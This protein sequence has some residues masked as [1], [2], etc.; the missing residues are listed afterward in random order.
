MKCNNSQRKRLVW[1]PVTSKQTLLT[2]D[3]LL[4][5]AILFGRAFYSV[6]KGNFNT[7]FLTQ[8][9]QSQSF[10]TLRCHIHILSTP[11]FPLPRF[12]LYFFVT[13]LFVSY[14]IYIDDYAIRDHSFAP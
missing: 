9:S 12:F 1:C 14:A 7:Q 8:P 2:H 5:R 10:D 13:S 11:V 6:K 3:I 4:S